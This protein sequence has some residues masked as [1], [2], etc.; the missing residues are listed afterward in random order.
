[1]GVNVARVAPHRRFKSTV[2]AGCGGK[3]FRSCARTVPGP[4]Q[5]NKWTLVLRS[6]IISVGVKD[7]N[8]TR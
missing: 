8:A 2:G 1:M 4:R 5:T 3:I 7:T 6:I